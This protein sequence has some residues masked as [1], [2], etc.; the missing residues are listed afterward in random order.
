MD[1]PI[2]KK[3]PFTEV[4]IGGKNEPI[5]YVKDGVAYENVFGGP[6]RA[7]DTTKFK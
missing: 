1:L 7:I 5:G 6:D 2:L 3:T 4:M